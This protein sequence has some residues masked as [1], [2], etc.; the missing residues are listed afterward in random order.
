[1]V[2]VGLI[3]EVFKV[4]AQDRIQQRFVEQNTLNFQFLK[5]VVVGEVFLVY[6]QTRI[7]L[8]HPRTLL[9]RMRFSR[10]VSHFFPR[11]GKC[12]VGSTLGVGTECGLYFTAYGVPMVPEPVLEV[13][14][15][16]EYLVTGMDE[17]GRW[18][19][20]SEVCVGRWFLRDTSHG[21]VWW[22][23]PGWGWRGF[24]FWEF[25]PVVVQRQ[26]LGCSSSCVSLL[27]LSDE[28]LHF[29]H[30]QFTLGNMV[31]YFLL[32]LYL[33][34]PRPVSGCCMRKTK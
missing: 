10:G 9:L 30:A 23:E 20:R 25:L 28:F 4:H 1:M 27:W 26:V 6:A 29:L 5:V 14:S 21:V 32:A 31:H 7:Q 24:K 3:G 8:L 15:E 34:V 33:A 13:E 11:G 17:C 2:V 12:D 22:D 16:E 18:W 19:S